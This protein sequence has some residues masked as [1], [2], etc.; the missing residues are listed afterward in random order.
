MLLLFFM[1]IIYP[2]L[3]VP[4]EAAKIVQFLLLNQCDTKYKFIND[5]F[6]VIKL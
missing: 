3:I 1:Y 2:K 5:T 4:A 6:L